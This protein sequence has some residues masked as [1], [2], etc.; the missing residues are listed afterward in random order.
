V[1]LFRH[2]FQVSIGAAGG[3]DLLLGAMQAHPNNGKLQ[4]YAFVALFNLSKHASVLVCFIYCG[5]I[6]VIE[7]YKLRFIGFVCSPILPLLKVPAS[8]LSRRPCATIP[9]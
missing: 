9:S 6:I 4:E 8:R 5:V 1:F 2:A 7:F 3:I